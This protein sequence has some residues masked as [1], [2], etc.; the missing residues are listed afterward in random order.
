MSH[1]ADVPTEPATAQAYRHL[2]RLI[3]TLELPPGSA[4]T[5][6]ALIARVGLGRT[7]M[8][9]AIQRLAW[10]GFLE[11]RPRS[12][13]SVAALHPGDW[14]KVVDARRGVE[15]TLAR[16]AARLATPQQS[17]DVER[18]AESMRDAAAEGD[19]DAFMAADRRADEAIAQASDNP[20]AVRFAAPL[21]THSRRFWF[22]Y[23]RSGDLLAAAEH[24]I[25]LL[26]AIAS[27]D[28]DAAARHADRLMTHL[29]TQAELLALR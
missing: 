15:I 17:R 8:R 5:E 12:G 7:P 19:A 13:I 29:R 26:K 18:A 24:H 16:S 22:R 4:T 9:E 2:E 1:E 25:R 10:E 21:Q 20:F 3:V 23:Q 6:T 14:L 11:I 27:H 28:E